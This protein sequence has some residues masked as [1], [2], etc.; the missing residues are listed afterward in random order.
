VKTETDKMD[1]SKTQQ[2][3]EKMAEGEGGFSTSHLLGDT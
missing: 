1:S 3:L 2:V